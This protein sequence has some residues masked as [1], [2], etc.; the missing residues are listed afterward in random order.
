ML[1]N[2][3]ELKCMVAFIQLGFECSVPYGNG[4]IEGIKCEKVDNLD[5][6]YGGGIG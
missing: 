5:G 4:A 2:S 6:G 1:G 3:N